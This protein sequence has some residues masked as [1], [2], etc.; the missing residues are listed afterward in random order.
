MPAQGGAVALCLKFGFYIKLAVV[1]TAQ[2]KLRSQIMKPLPF[3]P[4]GRGPSVGSLFLLCLNDRLGVLLPLYS[5]LGPWLKAVTH[6][7][8]IADCLLPFL[9]R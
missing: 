9:C 4:F 6:A 3:L 7:N 2:N 1:I 8:T 5:L